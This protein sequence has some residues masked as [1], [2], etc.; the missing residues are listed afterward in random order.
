MLMKYIAVLGFSFISLGL[1]AQDITFEANK[2]ALELE[3]ELILKVRIKNADNSDVT[4]FPSILGFQKRGRTVSHAEIKQNGK[5]VLQHIIEQKYIASQAGVFQLDSIHFIIN[6]TPYNFD[7]ITLTVVDSEEKTTQANSSGLQLYLYVNK[8]T[9]YVREGLKL[10]IGLLVP[11]SN[12]ESF[13]FS[14]NLNQEIANL[15]KRLEPEDCLIDRRTIT[16]IV[17]TDVK[18]QDEDYVKYMLYE[19]VYYPII[20][21]EIILPAVSISVE[22]QSKADTNKTERLRL[23]SNPF[24][25]FVNKLP[26]HP[27]SEII[28]VGQL[29]LSSPKFTSQ[30][31]TGKIYDFS[32]T[33]KGEGNIKSMSINKPENDSRFDFYPPKEAEKV[34]A[35]KNYGQK[36]FTFKVFPKK[37]EDV[38]LG[39]YFPFIYFNSR[40]EKYDTLQIDMPIQLNGTEIKNTLNASEDIY[41]QIE[42]LDI[43]EPST[44]YRAIIKNIANI[45]LFLGIGTVLINLYWHK[46]E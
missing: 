22:K 29:S 43:T 19:A 16:N 24:T 42:K 6:E 5:K 23:R 13:E 37:P 36:T 38:N 44:N 12:T 11:K 3:D 26:P 31:T 9:I 33:L 34:Y 20:E 8:S 7:P 21:Q 15:S 32:V 10:N 25:T 27:L 1:L 18:F 4:P 45:L 28:P 17:A 14:K 40:E 39:S 41:S 2:T 46:T 30:L 35:G